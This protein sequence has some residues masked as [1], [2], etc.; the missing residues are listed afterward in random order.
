MTEKTLP[1]D[2]GTSSSLSQNDADYADAAHLAAL[3]HGKNHS[4]YVVSGFNLNVDFGANDVVVS[5]GQARILV[6]DLNSVNHGDG[7]T[8]WTEATQVVRKEAE[9]VSLSF[10]QNHLYVRFRQSEVDN[11]EF[12]TTSGSDPAGESLKIGIIDTASNSVQHVNREP[13]GVFSGLTVEGVADIAQAAI[14][15]LSQSIDGNSKGITNLDNI[16]SSSAQ[17]SDSPSAPEDVARKA[18]IDSKADT[19]AA[20]GHATTHEAGGDDELSVDQLKGELEDPQPPKEH[21]NDAHAEEFITVQNAEDVLQFDTLGPGRAFA[22]EPVDLSTETMTSDD[23]YGLFY[24]NGAGDVPLAGGGSRSDA[25]YYRYRHTDSAFVAVGQHA[26]F[27]SGFTA[28]QFL[29][30]NGDTASGPMF[31]ETDNT[32]ALL[33]LVATDPNDYPEL[34]LGSTDNDGMKMRYYEGDQELWFGTWDDSGGFSKNVGID[35]VNGGF[36]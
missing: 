22:I 9:T 18:D 29:L 30:E 19:G 17:V 8:T 1:Q 26:E 21:N 11:P 5:D 6:T 28:E 2:Q 10:G 7:T 13:D 16:E 34:R 36:I 23:D 14:D 3:A 12:V 35:L 20:G 15:K 32:N 25:G 4:D 33:A 27:L 31:I 24:H